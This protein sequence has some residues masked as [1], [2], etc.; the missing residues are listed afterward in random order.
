MSL[1]NLF[2][3]LSPHE[4][5]AL[6]KLAEEQAPAAGKVRALKPILA[7]VAG[8]G[9]GTLAGAGAGHYANEI[10]KHYK[11]QNIPAKALVAAA[12]IVGGG[13]GL[14][15]HLAQAHQMEEMRRAA[16]GSSHKS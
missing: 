6:C 7:G 12:P 3:Y 9:L 1:P 14:A 2:S 10:Y 5:A 4:A 15:Y 13:L 16:E 11:G 8:M